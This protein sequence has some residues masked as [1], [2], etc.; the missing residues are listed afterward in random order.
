MKKII[1]RWTVNT[2]A[3]LSLSLLPA[4][5]RATLQP[6]RD[7]VEEVMEAMC[8]AQTGIS[9]EE[10]Q[11]AETS[12]EGRKAA[13]D[14]LF[15]EPIRKSGYDP[16]KSLQEFANKIINDDCTPEERGV[17]EKFLPF[18]VKWAGDLGNMGLIDSRTAELLEK[19]QLGGT[20]TQSFPV[21]HQF[22]S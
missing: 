20:R 19:V 22:Q 17:I 7:K 5:S 2:A 11:A 13:Y 16:D 9:A 1:G 6:D 15:I 18:Y 14:K 3:L 4:C 8:Q 10:G 12:T 21:R